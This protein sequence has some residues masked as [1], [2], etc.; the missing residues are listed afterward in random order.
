LGSFGLIRELLAEG[1]EFPTGMAFLGPD[2]I[3][4]IEKNTGKLKRIINGEILEEPLLD[5]NVANEFERGLLGIAVAKENSTTRINNE[6]TP[7]TKTYVFLYFSESS[8]K[9]DGSDQCEKKNYCSSGN[10]TG[11]R[12]YRYELKDNKLINPQ[13]LVDLPANPGPDHLGGV[14]AVGPDKNVYLV[15]GDGDSCAGGSCEDGIDHS[16]IN[17]QTANVKK[18]D[19]SSG[20]GGILRVTED[21]KVVT[22]KDSSEGDLEGREG[23]ILGDEHPLDMYFAYGI[24]NSFGIDFD[25]ITGNLW[26]TENGPG[27]GD[28]INLVEPGFN[29]GWMK[30][31]GIWPITSYELLD[32]TPE[33]SGYPHNTE[34]SQEPEN[35]V[36]FDNRGKYSNPEFTWDSP[37]GVTAIKFF[38]SEKLGQKYKDD[39][40]VGDINNGNIYHFDLVEDRTQL[41]LNKPLLDKVADSKEEDD[42]LIFAEEFDGITD[43]E[44]GPNGYLYA[45]SAGGSIHRIVKVYEG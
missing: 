40:F 43:L 38:N 37:V 32:P 42:E 14:I 26:D 44:L 8:N 34:I 21:G 28:E 30:A 6:L 17:A 45:L 2:D 41:S 7:Y 27:F 4:V 22:N 24:R 33:D 29:S 18:G 35:L 3:L 23:R 9:E 25:P 20:R 1:L 10:P 11:H 13:L 31:Q 15:T 39:I 16:V 19:P 36:S 12:L 5:T